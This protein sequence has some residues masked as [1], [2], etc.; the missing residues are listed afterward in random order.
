MPNGIPNKNILDRFNLREK[1]KQIKRSNNR[2]QRVKTIQTRNNDPRLLSK[3]K[4]L[5]GPKRIKFSPSIPELPD[6]TIF[7]NKEPV[8]YNGKY[9]TYQ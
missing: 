5:V 7:Y 1:E 9:V 2:R 3:K 4:P 6:G 8:I